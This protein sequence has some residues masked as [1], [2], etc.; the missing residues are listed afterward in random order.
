MKKVFLLAFL[1]TFTLIFSF[2][3]CKKNSVAPIDES[4]QSS[5][6]NALVDGEFTSIYSYF[7]A[8]STQTL[9][10]V[11][12]KGG[13]STIQDL[14]IKSDLL[15]ECATFSWD[16]VSRVLTIDFGTT[17]CT[18]KDG[19]T[20]RGKIIATLT[21][22]YKQAGSSVSVTLENY[23]VNDMR[24]TGTKTI[25][26]QGSATVHIVVSNASV[27]TPKGTISWNADRTI[28][29][30][31]GVLTPNIIWDDEYIIAESANGTNR[32]GVSFTVQTDLQKPLVKKVICQKKDFISGVVSIHNSNG[33]VLSINFDPTGTEEC[34]KL[35]TVTYN[36][37]TKTIILR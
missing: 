28:Q 26:Y 17:N 36:G 8:Q 7:D 16:S 15:P 23:Y 20:R 27:V 25:T 11:A 9:G 3:G 32:K 5:E 35:A 33:D 2:T 21:G 1:L 29:K 24:V 12:E 31:A 37:V 19:L 4:I 30:S 10:S 34:N 14:Q 18:C 13:N 22:K 6:D